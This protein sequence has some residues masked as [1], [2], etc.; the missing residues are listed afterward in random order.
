MRRTPAPPSMLQT[1]IDFFMDAPIAQIETAME[2]ATVIVKRRL[3]QPVAITPT[4][5]SHRPA[6]ALS[7]A[8]AAATT[9]STAIN[10]V[11]GPVPVPMPAGG[12]T[13]KLAKPRQ[14]A[15]R[16]DAGVARTRGAAGA[17]VSAAAVPTTASAM[18]PR[19]RRP[20]VDITD[21]VLPAVPAAVDDT[22]QAA[23]TATTEPPPL[24]DQY[25]PAEDEA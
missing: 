10:P 18:A 17:A 1:I 14:R 15:K 25:V 11:T 22:T 5:R 8:V 7:P 24:P 13:T 2:V 6:P 23:S 20:A 19:R 16:K 4:R 3:A 12:K 21:A 9:P